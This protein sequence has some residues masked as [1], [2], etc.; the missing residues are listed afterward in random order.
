MCI[1]RCWSHKLYL[2]RSRIYNAIILDGNT[3]STDLT[4]RE[5]NLCSAT[6][7]TKMLDVFGVVVVVVARVSFYGSYSVQY[8]AV[9]PFLDYR[10]FWAV[11][12]LFCFFLHVHVSCSMQYFNVFLVVL[13]FV[14]PDTLM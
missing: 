14:K 5:F 11:R 6:R 13:F 1:Y 10:R 3:I 2:R 12:F 7:F 9:S 4:K 8:F